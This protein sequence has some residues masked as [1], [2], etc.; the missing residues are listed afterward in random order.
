MVKIDKEGSLIDL[1]DLLAIIKEDFEHE[2]IKDL[3]SYSI[4]FV[5][6]TDSNHI[7][8]VRTYV[9]QYKNKATRNQ[10]FSII[11]KGAGYVR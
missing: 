10:W 8:G 9:H 7:G 2:T 11:T 6:R 5:F 1:T 4:K 3:S